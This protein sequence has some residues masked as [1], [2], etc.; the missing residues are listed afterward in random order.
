MPLAALHA[1]WPMIFDK[2]RNCILIF[3]LNKYHVRQ[4]KRDVKNGMSFLRANW[5]CERKNLP[6]HFLELFGVENE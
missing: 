3:R 6:E 5:N 2:R 1:A 4:Y